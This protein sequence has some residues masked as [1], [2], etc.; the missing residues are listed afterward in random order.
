VTVNN[1]ININKIKH[2]LQSQ[3]NE[4]KKK[5]STYDMSMEIQF[6]YVWKFP[7]LMKLAKL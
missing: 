4:Q 1:A 2:H 3:T 7:H 5:A 6:M